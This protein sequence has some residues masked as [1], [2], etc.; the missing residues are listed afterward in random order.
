MTI[1]AIDFETCSVGFFDKEP[2]KNWKGHPRLA[3]PIILSFQNSDTCG[4]VELEKSEIRPPVTSMVVFHNAGFDLPIGEKVGC[5]S[6]QHIRHDSFD[7]TA[8]LARLSHNLR[9]AGLKNLAIQILNEEVTSYEATKEELSKFLEYAKKDAE[10][11]Y[12]LY[13]IL[14]YEIEAKGMRRLYEEVEKPFILINMECQQHGLQIERQ[15]VNELVLQLDNEIEKLKTK[16]PKNLNTASSTQ[17]KVLLYDELGL[18][19]QFQ[20]GRPSTSRKVLKKLSSNAMVNQLLELKEVRAKISQIKQLERFTDPITSRIHPFVNPLGADTG[21]ATSSNPNLQNIDKSSAL[22]EIFIASAGHKLL[23]FDFSQI[24]P[25]VLAHFLPGS[26]FANLFETD[27]DFYLKLASKFLNHIEVEKSIREVA[28]LV[29]LATFYGMGKNL[30]SSTLNITPLQAED[31]LNSFELSFPEITT[32]KNRV[33]SS[34]RDNGFATGLLGRRRY[35]ENLNSKDKFLCARAERQ[36]FNAVIQGSAATL[37][38]YKLIQLRHA[39]TRE[40]RFLHHV[41]DEVI[42]E[43]PEAIAA[44]SSDVCLKVLESPV[45]WFS[46]PIKVEGGIGSNWKEAKNQKM[47]RR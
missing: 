39:L 21:R 29:I 37:F 33:V 36:A 22:R 46:V 4:V 2:K 8:T 35:I 24:E 1:T 42:L 30:L 43:A 5:W 19:V 34:A 12:R 25:R 16:F 6:V 9:P 41:H 18:P 38:K 47:E 32:F 26:S 40:V 11:T 27:D 10:F 15:K 3:T 23:V 31:I 7:C 17:L 44:V 28:K 20:K 45:D 14:K 13:P